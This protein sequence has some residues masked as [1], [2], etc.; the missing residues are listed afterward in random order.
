MYS[1]NQI[2]T[3]PFE[4]TQHRVSGSLCFSG[5]KGLLSSS[6][7]LHLVLYRS[8]RNRPTSK[9][10]TAAATEDP[11][12]AA[13]TVLSFFPLDD[14]DAAPDATGTAKNRLNKR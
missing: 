5:S 11:I 3:E 7:C 9:N 4:R 8:I 1:E 12:T 10:A 2:L 14:E 13:D 6:S